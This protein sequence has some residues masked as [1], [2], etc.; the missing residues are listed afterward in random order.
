M[1]SGSILSPQIKRWTPEL[2]SSKK[3][4]PDPDSPRSRSGS[5]ISILY[6]GPAMRG[7]APENKLS[8]K[9]RDSDNYRV[10]NQLSSLN[11]QVL[12]NMGGQGGGNP[13]LQ[14]SYYGGSNHPVSPTHLDVYSRG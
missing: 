5:S 9:K 6:G 13:Y 7:G 8:L 1:R 4:T 11:S 14:G 3:N 12:P 10:G 2:D